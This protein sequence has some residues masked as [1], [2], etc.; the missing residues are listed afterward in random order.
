MWRD[1]GIVTMRN[2][3]IVLWRLWVVRGDVELSIAEVHH[4]GYA[5]ALGWSLGR[6]ASSADSTMGNPLS[7]GMRHKSRPLEHGEQRTS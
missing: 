5:A 1:L 3:S 2:V 6:L 7:K 4:P